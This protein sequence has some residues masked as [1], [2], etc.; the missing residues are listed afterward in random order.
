MG[1]PS[2]VQL[3]PKTPIGRR[4]SRNVDVPTASPDSSEASSVL[5]PRR[6]PRIGTAFQH[7]LRDDDDL[8]LLDRPDP[9]PMSRDI[10]YRTEQQV[11][12]DT[13]EDQVLE[14]DSVT[15]STN[16]ALHM[17]Y[18]AQRYHGVPRR[19]GRL[20]H[21]ALSDNETI[22]SHHFVGYCEPLTTIGLP[23]L[24][25]ETLLDGAAF[26]DWTH[27]MLRWHDALPT[28][29]A[30]KSRKSRF[31]RPRE[32]DVLPPVVMAGPSPPPTKYR[33][34]VSH[35]ADQSRLEFWENQSHQ[36]EQAC[37]KALVDVVDGQAIVG[38][39]ARQ[40]KQYQER[41]RQPQKESSES[42]RREF[43]L[44]MAIVGDYRSRRDDTRHT[45]CAANGLASIDESHHTRFGDSVLSDTEYA[46]SVWKA[47]LACAHSMENQITTTE[48][49]S[50]CVVTLADLLS[51]CSH[52]YQLPLPEDVFKGAEASH[53]VEEISKAMWALL[54]LTHTA[55]EDHAKLA[56]AWNEK[57]VDVETLRTRLATVRGEAKIPLREFAELER[58][59]AVVAEWQTRLDAIFA[60]EVVDENRNDVAALETLACQAKSHGFCSRGL[61]QLERKLRN[62]YELR[63]RILQWRV[64]SA[65]GN[66]ESIKYIASIVRDIHRGRLSCPE[67]T[68]VLVFHRNAEA[69]VDRAMIAIRSRISLSEIKALI[70][71]GNA[72]PLDLSEYQEKLASR[73]KSAED[74]LLLVHDIVPAPQTSHGRAGMLEWMA[75]VRKA[76]ESGHGVLHELA[77]E[78]SRIP[79]EVDYVKLL[80]VELDARG[81]TAKARK[82]L[83]DSKAAD[84]EN[85]SKKGKLEDLRE[86]IDKATSLRERLVLAPEDCDAWILDGEKELVGIVDAADSWYEEYEE[87]LDGDNRRSGG[88]SCLSLEKLRHITHECDAIH[89]NIGSASVKIFKILAQ[90]ESWYHKY[91]YLMDYCQDRGRIATK[92]RLEVSELENAVDAAVS[93]VALDLE[94]AIE[95]R[96]LLKRIES[97][98]DRASIV[99]GDKRRRAGKK[100]TFTVE[101]LAELIDEAETLPIEAKENVRLL[102]AQLAS[103]ESW[104]RKAAADLDGI[105][106]GF[107]HLR[108]AIVET[109]GMPTAF[110]RES[111]KENEGPNKN[112]MQEFT[113]TTEA[114]SFSTDVTTSDDEKKLIEDNVSHCGTVSTMASDQ[115]LNSLAHLGNGECT[116]HAM[117]KALGRDGKHSCLI[118]PEGEI[119]TQ[120]DVVWRWCLRS[121]KYLESHRDIFDKRFFGA[122]D[123]FLAEGKDLLKASG[124]VKEEK[125]LLKRVA[126][127]WGVVVGDQLERLGVLLSE[128]EEFVAWSD[129]VEHA[130]SLEDKRL[131]IE[132]LREFERL[133]NSFPDA[134]EL[135]QQ[136]KNLAEEANAWIENAQE[137]LEG[138]NKMSVQ[139]AKLLFDDGLKLGIQCNEIRLLRNGLKTARGWAGRVKRCKTDQG[140]THVNSVKALISE[141]KSL[142]VKMPDELQRLRQALRNYCICR[143]PYEGFMIGCDSCEEWFHGSCIGVSESKADRVDKYVCIRCSVKR[144]FKSSARDIVSII[145][146][147]TNDKELKKSRQT[148]AQKH[149]R[150]VRKEVKDSE[151]LEKEREALEEQLRSLENQPNTSVEGLPS[152]E[153]REGES[154]DILCNLGHSDDAISTEAKDL[155]TSN[156]ENANKT[157]DGSSI[158]IDA[159]QCGENTRNESNTAPGSV[160]QI[161]DSKLRTETKET[162]VAKIEKARRALERSRSRLVGLHDSALRRKE[163]ESF[164][165]AHMLALKTWCIRVRSL[166]LVPATSER[167]DRGRPGLDGTLS[168]AMVLLLDE[169]KDRGLLSLK[170]VEEIINSFM[171]LCWSIRATAILARQPQVSEVKALIEQGSR[172]H[173]PDEKGLRM[174]K[175]MLQRAVTWNDKVCKAVAPVPGETKAF[176]LNTLK[177]LAIAGDDIPLAMTLEPRLLTIIEDEGA[178]HCLCGGPSDGR[179]MLSCDKCEC[180]FHGSC[181]GVDKKDS[182]S[183][184]EWKCPLCAGK[185]PD[186]CALKLDKFHDTFDVDV[187]DASDD[188]DVSSKAPNPEE[189]WP[190]FGLAHSTNAVEALGQDCS[191]IPEASLEWKEFGFSNSQT[192]ASAPR[193]PQTEVHVVLESKPASIMETVQH[194]DGESCVTIHAPAVHSSLVATPQVDL[195]P[196]LV[197]SSVQ[198][199][200]ATEFA[201]DR[202]MRKDQTSLNWTSVSSES[203]G[204]IDTDGVGIG[205]LPNRKQLKTVTGS[206]NVPAI[207][208]QPAVKNALNIDHSAS[209]A[210]CEGNYVEVGNGKK[211]MQ[212]EASSNK[213]LAVAN[214]KSHGGEMGIE[215]VKTAERSA[216]KVEAIESGISTTETNEP[217]DIEVLGKSTLEASAAVASTGEW[218]DAV[219]SMTVVELPADIQ[220][221]TAAEVHSIDIDLVKPSI[222]PIAVTQPEVLISAAASLPQFN[223]VLSQSSTEMKHAQA[224]PC[225]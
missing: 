206:A 137:S 173:L 188:D 91:R 201:T 166:V 192:T 110:S 184:D 58:Q 88:R 45:G 82:W 53:M 209:A 59:L 123:R 118:T 181:V 8:T 149:Q 84:E 156:L 113:E 43:A 214:A 124:L 160:G 74:W 52:A 168:P 215:N 1:R 13:V 101:A 128:R 216:E 154:G 185:V 10:P 27:E 71:R 135:V 50:T 180:W 130:L 17:G 169:A 68:D 175:Q 42:W 141:H 4:S 67:F 15:G 49:P 125:G 197:F 94:E 34:V 114:K 37:W 11:Q 212:S 178:R 14:H 161:S 121:L 109:Y 145:R 22:A 97:W 2:L 3:G 151:K 36:F 104:Q 223:G 48:L 107:E 158:T 92:S 117:I 211:R 70:E 196:A 73:V 139:E 61:R 29:G 103:I 218:S 147:W 187:D 72:M 76:L 174:M 19:G 155:T 138:G 111:M 119:A 182:D 35:E 95:L 171:C 162:L 30:N 219:K 23:G 112:V 208:N 203:S 57:G 38:L 126:V 47:V 69:W 31:K 165:D 225:E 62:A 75:R 153:T 21:R 18:E 159:E 98:C 146:K 176:S 83:P 89:A 66:R 64:L 16:S 99:I 5:Y 224:S 24:G 183:L 222:Q 7:K 96:D 148:I 28:A 157:S 189:M 200:I 179:F 195:V 177:D 163:Q 65:R 193:P 20:L 79:V 167:A 90:A 204:M 120:L 127:S 44:G 144:I 93:E 51:F 81:W 202:G 122:F 129:A 152:C 150:K 41:F 213:K 170:D 217:M 12:R 46:K 100:I 54:N 55:R 191:L 26:S 108:E 6:H 198:V 220:I 87:F 205:S 56:D 9:I 210:E 140:E 39:R 105:V 133:S 207:T 194:M 33:G 134:V 78:G 172:L 186:L 77:C 80:Q 86:H 221:E 102:K 32:V 199:P 106:G 132:K 142:I 164:E 115:E 131:T 85:S 63:H 116:I 60:E 136:V 40:R 143:R 190:P 25:A